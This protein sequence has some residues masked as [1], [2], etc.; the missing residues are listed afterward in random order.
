MGR[1]VVTLEGIPF[2]IQ[3]YI[4]VLIL[5]EHFRIF[6]RA[7]DFKKVIG[8]FYLFQQA[9]PVHRQELGSVGIL[10]LELKR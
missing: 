2:F 5:L 6:M 4:D 3:L 9:F 10:F 1:Q 8:S 7:N